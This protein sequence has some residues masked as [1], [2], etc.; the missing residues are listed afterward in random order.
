[1]AITQ[2]YQNTGQ[3]FSAS[4]AGAQT[5]TAPGSAG[6]GSSMSTTSGVLIII[7]GSLVALIALAYVMRVPLDISAT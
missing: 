4:G 7:G 2:E 1:M 6:V 5:V 3:A